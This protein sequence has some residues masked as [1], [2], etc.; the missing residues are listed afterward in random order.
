METGRV[1]NHCVKGTIQVK[2][3]IHLSA[4]WDDVDSRSGGGITPSEK[5]QDSSPVTGLRPQLSGP[6]PARCSTSWLP[7]ERARHSIVAIGFCNHCAILTIPAR[8]N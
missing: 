7:A 5:R 8:S 4:S 2:R 6:Y 3:A 1:G